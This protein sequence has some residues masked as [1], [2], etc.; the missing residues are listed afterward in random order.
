MEILTSPPRAAVVNDMG[1][2]EKISLPFLWKIGCEPTDTKIRLKGKGVPSIQN[3][4]IRGDHYVTLIVQVP[5]KLNAQQ[6]D[7]LRQ[8]EAT[9]GGK[10]DGGESKKKGGF[11]TKK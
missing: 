5:I 2:D 1:A 10:A 9:F 7:L 11:F 8:Y 4:E 3:K 6:R